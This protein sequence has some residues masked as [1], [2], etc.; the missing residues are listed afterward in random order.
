M[1]DDTRTF[2]LADVLSVTTSKLLCRFQDMHELAEWIAGHPI[3]SH[4]FADRELHERL[5]ESVLADHPDLRE[6]DASEVNRDNW[7]QYLDRWKEQYGST[8]EIRRGTMK[9]EEDPVASAT[10]LMGQQP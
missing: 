6:V 1:S 8:R 5:K 2:P 3:W 7:S 9:R 10:R 4:E